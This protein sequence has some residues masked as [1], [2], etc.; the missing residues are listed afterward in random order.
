MPVQARQQR[1]ENLVSEAAF[2]SAWRFAYSLTG[3]RADAE[4]LLQDAL[5]RA[6]RGLDGLRDESRFTGW[7]LSIVRTVHLDSLR[8][9]RSRPQAYEEPPPYLAAQDAE[10]LSPAVAEALARLPHAQ[11]QLLALFYLEGLSL[12]ETG[13]ALGIGSQAVRQRLFRSRSALRR[14]LGRL[15][16][17]VPGLA[18]PSDFGGEL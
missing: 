9:E 4:D 12:E 10:P 7:L 16:V 2:R 8:R 17:S 13:M 3:S 14:E 6:Y 15:G 18:V 1:F 5:I 11:Q